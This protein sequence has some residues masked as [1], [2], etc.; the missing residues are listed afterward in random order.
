[1][2]PTVSP[3]TAPAGSPF[4]VTWAS[5]PP[6]SGYAFDVRYRRDGSSSWTT[7]QS[8][9]AA[10][11][12]QYVPS[13]AGKYSFEARL[14]NTATVPATASDWSSPVIATAS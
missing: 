14:V 10:V 1:M 7:W 2:L 3:S 12:A 13:R 11:S 9:V 6:A 5:A 8:Q 4:T